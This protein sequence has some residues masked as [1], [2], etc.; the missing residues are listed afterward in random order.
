MITGED[1]EAEPRLALALAAP[2]AAG[3][4]DLVEEEEFDERQRGVGL[5][6]LPCVRVPRRLGIVEAPQDQVRATQ[7]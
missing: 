3:L 6:R 4:G 1:E 7:R 2:A 5:V